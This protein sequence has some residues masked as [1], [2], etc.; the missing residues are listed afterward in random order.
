M[1]AFRAADAA[2]T[3][4]S[5]TAIP[6]RRSRWRSA[7]SARR[8][9]SPD[10]ARPGDPAGR[11]Q[12]ARGGS[13]APVR[14]SSAG[15]GCGRPARTRPPPA[16]RDLVRAAFACGELS[17]E[18]VQRL[19]TQRVG[20]ELRH[21]AVDQPDPGAGREPFLQAV[22]ERVREPDGNERSVPDREVSVT[23]IASTRPYQRTPPSRAPSSGASRTLRRLSSN[24]LATSGDPA[25]PR[26]ASPSCDHCRATT[27]R[28]NAARSSYC[29]HTIA[30]KPRASDARRASWT[31]SSVVEVS[32]EDIGI[33][34][35]RTSRQW[36]FNRVTVA[37]RKMREC[38]DVATTLAPKQPRG[39]RT[40]R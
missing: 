30:F 18:L 15:Q 33:A 1:R 39:P 7:R 28:R 8:P 3:P 19:H 11:G 17:G 6:V 34:A 14:K 38:R 4:A 5:G 31:S 40:R 29:A 10:G 13:S 9:T 16:S 20:G 27:A 2:E 36:S 12:A 26:C 35:L 21:G 25:T 22:P 23:G 37:I 32:W 24:R